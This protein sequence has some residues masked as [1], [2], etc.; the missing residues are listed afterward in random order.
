MT[1]G[2]ASVE[3]GQA[4]ASTAVVVA[5]SWVGGGDSY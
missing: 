4:E 5:E 3:A 2:A 1:G